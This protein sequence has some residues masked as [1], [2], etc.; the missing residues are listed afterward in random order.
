[1]EGGGLIMVHVQNLSHSCD[2][3]FTTMLQ[4]WGQISVYRLYMYT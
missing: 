2:N 3:V 4:P 1:M